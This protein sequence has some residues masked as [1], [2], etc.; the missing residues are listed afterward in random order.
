MLRPRNA[1]LIVHRGEVQE[2][3]QAP[4]K[5]ILGRDE[6]QAVTVL[7]TDPSRRT[8]PG[9]TPRWLGSGLYRSLTAEAQALPHLRGV[10][11]ACDQGER[12]TARSGALALLDA[13]IVVTVLPQRPGR[14]PNGSRFDTNSIR[15]EPR[16][17]S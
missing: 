5:P 12:V 9:N 4:W 14:M 10:G 16:R 6:W 8:S 1:G 15:I 13:L 2:G 17:P 11:A 7:L 3:V